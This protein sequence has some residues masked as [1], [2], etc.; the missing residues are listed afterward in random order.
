MKREF[1]YPLLWRPILNMLIMSSKIIIYCT[2]Y[3]GSLKIQVIGGLVKHHNV[4]NVPCQHGN[5]Y[6]RL[7]PPG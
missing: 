5:C 7:L 2:T 4:R 1:F 6:T 3:L